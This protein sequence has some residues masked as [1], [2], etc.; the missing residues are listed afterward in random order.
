VAVHVD[1]SWSDD[2]PRDI[3][4][5]LTWSRNESGRYLG[6]AVAAKAHGGGPRLRTSAVDDPTIHEQNSRGDR[7]RRREQH[8][9]SE[10]E[11]G[12]HG[13]HSTALRADPGAALFC[14]SPAPFNRAA[15]GRV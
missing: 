3:Q 11:A 12:A 4:N 13:R 1:E 15:G 14:L 6:D 10:N 9:Q 5:L 2:E 7:L 8:G